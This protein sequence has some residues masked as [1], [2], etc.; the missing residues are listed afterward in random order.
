MTVDPCVTLVEEYSQWLRQGLSATAIDSGCELTTPFLDRHNDH[1]QVYAERVGQRVLLSDDGYTLADLRASGLDI[2]TDKRREVFETT[3]AGFGVK[4]RD[5]EL[6][7][8]ASSSNLGARVHGLVQ[9]MLAVN[10]MHVMAQ[11]RVA[12]FFFEDVK[13]FL[14]ANDVRHVDRVK[15][16]G[17]SGYDHRIDFLIPRS[18]DRPERFVQAITAPTKDLIVPYLFGI[19]ETRQTRDGDVQAFAFLDD[20][21]RTVG[22]GVQEALREYDIAPAPWSQRDEFAE[23]LAA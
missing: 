16:T 22:P 5:G 13:A 7:A 11:A 14:D 12:G 18:N 15:I 3:L 9:A 21:S 19:S 23:A 1:L 6:T 17:R 4:V 8:E 10:D 2:D 20:Q